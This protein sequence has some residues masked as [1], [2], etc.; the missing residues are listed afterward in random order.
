MPKLYYPTPDELRGAR[1]LNEQLWF[2]RFQS[3]L[4][5]LAN[6]NEGR[7]LLCLDSWRKRPYPIVALEKNRACYYVGQTSHDR[8]TF[9]SDLRAGAKWGNVS[10]SR[11]KYIAPA[12]SRMALEEM[13]LWPQLGQRQRLAAARFTTTE[14]FPDPDP[15]STTV[16][17]QVFVNDLGSVAYNTLRDDTGSGFDST[18]A[19]LLNPSLSATT[20]TDQ[21]NN[22]SR[23]VVLTDSAGIDDGDQID[24]ATFEFVATLIGADDM[25]GDSLSFVLLDAALA[26]NTAL[27]AGDFDAVVPSGSAA[28]KQA[29]DI[30]LQSVNTDG[31]TYNVLTFNATGEGNISKTGVESWG[32]ILE[33]DASRTAPTWASDG[34]ANVT[35]DTAEQTGTTTDPKVV[36]VHSVPF[37]NIAGVGQTLGQIQP[38]MIPTS[39]VPY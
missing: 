20:T 19:E 39:V 2:P 29:T 10:R 6:T 30:T 18:A 27:A 14:L 17:G 34:R 22:M 3:V 35:I 32:M 5:R 16:D 1:P 26:S 21:Y 4:L 31:A 23:Y 25:G 28:T 8:V 9:I 13:L 11:W 33:T 15:E 36:V 12:L 37:T 24:S 7:D 38:M